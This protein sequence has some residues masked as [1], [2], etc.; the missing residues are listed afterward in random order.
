M[1]TKK[2]RNQKGFTLI[3]II[4]V[5]VILGILA[6]IAIPKYMDMQTE[7]RNKATQGA[8]GSASGEVSLRYANMLLS[9]NGAAPSMSSL[10]AYL[11]SNSTLLGDYTFSYAASGTNGI[12]ITVTSVAGGGAI[13][14]PSSKN[15]VVQ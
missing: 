4:A 9:A 6:A 15:L 13:G 11:T 14:T 1:L 3:E 8:L 12:T 10:A 2:I 7:S 5:L